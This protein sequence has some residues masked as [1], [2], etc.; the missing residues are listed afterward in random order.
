MRWYGSCVDGARIHL[1]ALKRGYVDLAGLRERFGMFLRTMGRSPGARL[2][3]AAFM[4]AGFRRA[5]RQPPAVVL[6]QGG[7]EWFRPHARRHEIFSILPE[8][9]RA[10]TRVLDFEIVERDLI[11]SDLKPIQQA[12]CCGQHRRR[13]TEI[14]L[15]GVEIRMTLQQAFVRGLVHQSLD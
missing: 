10:A 12:P 2:E 6:L 3:C 14:K 13:P 1:V 4:A 15:A 11:L 5:K 7:V 8:A 9:A